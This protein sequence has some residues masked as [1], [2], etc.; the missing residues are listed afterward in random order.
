VHP[1]AEVGETVMVNSRQRAIVDERRFDRGSWTALGVV[2][3][4]IEAMITTTILSLARV[5]DGCLMGGQ[6]HSCGEP[7]RLENWL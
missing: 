5:G 4:V 7:H 6:Q 3:V 1:E 2:L